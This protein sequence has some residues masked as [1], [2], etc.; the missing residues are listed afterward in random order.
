MRFFDAVVSIGYPHHPPNE[1]LT[2]G[3]QGWEPTTSEA[4]VFKALGND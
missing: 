1:P 4:A 3:A 2:S